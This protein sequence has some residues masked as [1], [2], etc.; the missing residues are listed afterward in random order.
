M[1]VSV[2]SCVSNSWQRSR[3]SFLVDGNI[4]ISASGSPINYRVTSYKASVVCGQVIEALYSYGRNTSFH[5]V[6]CSVWLAS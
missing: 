5:Y 6:L 3:S 2:V 4:F 1:F